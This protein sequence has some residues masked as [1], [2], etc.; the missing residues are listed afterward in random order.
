MA[1]PTKTDEW[2]VKSASSTNFN[3]H[4]SKSVP[5]Q[6][7]G[8]ND[9]LL[10]IKAI[11]L[12]YRDLAIARGT[13]PLPTTFP[14]IPTSDASAL[15][16]ATGAA[17]TT[18][19]PGTPVLILPAPL[20]TT[21]PL[22]SATHAAPGDGHHPGL[23]RRHAVLPA[24]WVARYP[25]HL[26]YVEAATIGAAGL[27][28]W[29]ALFGAGLPGVAGGAG[30]RGI[31]A[32]DVVL[33]QGTGAVALFAAGFAVRA[34][35]R[36]IGTTSSAGKTRWLRAL[37]VAEVLNYREDGRWGETARGLTAGGEGVD[38][39]VD[40]GGAGTLGQSLRAI[41]YDGTV[42]VTGFLSGGEDGPGPSL[43]EVLPRAANVR[44]I[45]AGSRA[46]YEEMVGKMEEWEFRP[47]VDER[48]FGFGEVEEAYEY[49]WAQKHVG[50]V[51]IEVAK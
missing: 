51:V 34:G 35:A 49:L 4:L 7:L 45:L 43:M 10:E 37:G 26:S 20:H 24:S 27:T 14:L 18:L 11:S 46:Q 17:I 47:V 36:V 5:I 42:A 50:K 1:L 25:A 39:V 28:A 16:L 40:V 8:P 21:G 29:N 12:N 30:P 41:R 31:R 44:G 38:L 9:V 6:S 23:L 15:I 32:G 3:L 2:V 22:T 13:Y 19:A 48:V 33:T